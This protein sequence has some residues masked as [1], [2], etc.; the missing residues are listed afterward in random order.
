[1]MSVHD[2][3]VAWQNA[4]IGASQAMTL[5]GA[6]DIFELYALAETCG[7]ELRFELSESEQ[8]TLRRVT[9]AIERAIE[10]SGTPR[11]PAGAEAA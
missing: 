7:V 8:R 11:G 1:M 3:L 10:R 5:S 2:A 4:E 9:K 6:N